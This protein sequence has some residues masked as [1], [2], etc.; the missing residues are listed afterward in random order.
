MPTKSKA[1]SEVVSA[2]LKRAQKA[3]EDGAAAMAKH[4]ADARAVDEKTARLKSLRLAK[5]AEPESV[6][7]KRNDWKQSGVRSH[8]K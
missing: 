3:A 8:D 6:R 5:E 2:R 4:H 7:P 1:S